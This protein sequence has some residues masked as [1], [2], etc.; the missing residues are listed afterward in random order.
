MPV[1]PSFARRRAPA[2]GTG[3]SSGATDRSGARTGTDTPP[4]GREVPVRRRRA[5][6]ARVVVLLVVVV[7]L[8]PFVV[9]QGVGQMGVVPDPADVPER[10]VALVLGAG[11]RPSGEPSPYLRRRLDAAVD[12]YE[13]GVVE[14]VLVS[15]DRSGP[16]YDEPGAM[17]EY[18][19]AHG[20]PDDVVVRDDAGVDTHTSC[21]R[22]HD[23]FDVD[24][25]VV[26]TQDYHLRR[27][28]F[29]CRSAGIDAVGV[30]VSATSVRPV[31]AVGWRLREVPAA[32]KAV[33]DALAG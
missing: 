6:L 22:A 29:S 24:A 2:S 14:R 21:V 10:P 23:V 32:A 27:A 15:G 30:G 8:G 4:S 25:A 5:R 18:L 1:R 12:L 28:L 3:T 20:V 11:L 9:V 26:V 13:R 7:G 19:L 31:Q 33:L 16:H 17:R